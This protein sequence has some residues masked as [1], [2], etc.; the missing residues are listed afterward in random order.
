MFFYY[1]F[2]NVFPIVFISWRLITLQYCSG[3]KFLIIFQLLKSFSIEPL[4]HS[5]ASSNL[6][7]YEY[8]SKYADL[9]FCNYIILPAVLKNSL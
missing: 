6:N 2:F 4:I 7:I 8:F 5:Q 1:Y 3:F 9:F